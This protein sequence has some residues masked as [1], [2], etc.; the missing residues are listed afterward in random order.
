MMPNNH[1]AE[2]TATTVAGTVVVANGVSKSME[3]TKS[4][5]S[6]SIEQILSGDF[7]LHGSDVT[8]LLGSIFLVLNVWLAYRRW[9]FERKQSNE[10]DNC[11]SN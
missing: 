10:L 2:N 8:S 3:N 4:M 9:L 7:V 5:L 11:E 6:S 1:I